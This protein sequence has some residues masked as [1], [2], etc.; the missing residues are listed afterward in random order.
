[1]KVAKGLANAMKKVQ[2][3][4]SLAQQKGNVKNAMRGTV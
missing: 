3:S 1:M 4:L 2:Q